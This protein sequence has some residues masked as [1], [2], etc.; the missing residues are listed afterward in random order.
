[1]KKISPAPISRG[2]KAKISTTSSL[3]GARIWPT[4]RKLSAAMMPTSQMINLAI[5]P[6]W[7]PTV[8][9]GVPVTWLRSAGDLSIAFWRTHLTALATIQVATRIA[10]AMRILRTPVNQL[11][12]PISALVDL[13]HDS[14]PLWSAG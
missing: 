3:I 11:A 2:R 5:T 1:M 10:S 12:L 4:P 13:I 14:A 9:S 8:S 7:W 6:S